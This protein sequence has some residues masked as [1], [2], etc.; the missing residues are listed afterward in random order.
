MVGQGPPHPLAFAPLPPRLTT[1][2]VAPQLSVPRPPARHL[3]PPQ[4][5]GPARDACDTTRPR[6]RGLLGGVARPGPSS[7]PDNRQS[8]QAWAWREPAPMQTPLAVSAFA[9]VAAPLAL[10]AHRLPRFGKLLGSK[11]RRQR[12]PPTDR[13]LVRR[14]FPAAE[15][16]TPIN[17]WEHWRSR[18]DRV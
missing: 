14:I 11:A 10:H 5:P 16:A 1:L 13:P 18:V 4:A 15:Q 2:R 3:R 6:A 9:A 17:L 8:S 12:V 7:G